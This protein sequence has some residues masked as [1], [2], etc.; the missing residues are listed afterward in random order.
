M[1][2]GIAKE[3]QSTQKWKQLSELAINK[4]NLDL[5][6]ECLHEAQD[7]GGNLIKS[8][9]SVVDISG[10]MTTPLEWVY[11]KKKKKIS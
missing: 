3:A 10:F 2:H 1:A 4:M 9:Y 8:T 7:F 11:A 6:Q 5:A